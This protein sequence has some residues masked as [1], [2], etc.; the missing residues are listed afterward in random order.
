MI[1]N[2]EIIITILLQIII[3]NNNV[4]NANTAGVM[5]KPVCVSATRRPGGRQ[6]GGGGDRSGQRQQDTC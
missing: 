2:N 6:R 4:Y 1:Y 3:T 5:R